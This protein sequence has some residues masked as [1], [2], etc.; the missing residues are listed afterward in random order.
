MIE[1]M[2]TIAI[3]AVL[4]GLAAPSFTKVLQRNRI[5]TEANSLTADL[6]Y[7]R[8]QAIKEGLPVTVCI[9][10]DQ[11]SCSTSATDWSAGWIVFSD[12]NANQAVDT[13]PTAESVWRTQPSFSSNGSTDTFGDSTNR[14]F[15][16][17]RDGFLTGLPVGTTDVKLSLKTVPANANA[18]RC[19][20][21]NRIGRQAVSTGACP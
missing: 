2:V 5:A 13:T 21:I 20:T 1:L 7:A 16:Y 12:P 10:T 8:G 3:A 11:T 17:S 4:I 14:A 19:L 6:Q 15:T 9:S 18:A